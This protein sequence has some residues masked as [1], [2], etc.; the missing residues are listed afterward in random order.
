MSKKLTVE[1]FR[2]RSE[3]KHSKKYG[4]DRVKFDKITDK[5][6]ILCNACQEYFTQ[7]VNDHLRGSGCPKC[8]KCG[9]KKLSPEEFLSRCKEKYPTQ[10]DF[11]ETKYIVSENK[12][13]IRCNIC[14]HS[15]E[16]M[17]SDFLNSTVGCRKCA[18]KYR[19][20][21]RRISQ[22]EFLARMQILHGNDYDYSDVD[23]TTRDGKI[24]IYCKTCREFFFQKADYHMNGSKCPKCAHIS[25][26][27]KRSLHKKEIIERANLVHLGKYDYSFMEEYPTI[28]GGLATIVCSIHGQFFQNIGNHLDGC[29]CPTCAAE[30]RGKLLSLGKDEFVKRSSIMHVGMY[31]Y[32]KVVYTNAVTKVEIICSVHG[33]FW[34][35]PQHHLAGSG[36]PQCRISSGEREIIRFL[37]NKN[38]IYVF[39]KKF[40][41]LGRLSYD[42]Y[43]PQQ[44]I[45]IEYDGIQHFEPTDFGSGTAVALREFRLRKANDLLKTKY[46]SDN[47][48][49]LIR[50]AYKDFDRIEEILMT[51]LGE[52]N[53]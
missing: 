20:A 13:K 3:K 45:L 6:E 53:A 41:D 12:V 15:F 19:G 7:V 1:V 48:I 4:Y 46:A 39:E 22:K 52:T 10:F 17:P 21:K 42:F 14:G 16:V 27:Q 11:S 26:V 25:S 28:N 47:N 31:D 24:K 9:R 2:E 40:K 49:R 8:N 51:T 38:I 23:Y 44:N 30:E 43:L 32:S 36:C 5:V 33:V 50:I 29:G 35:E 18:D 34:Q 37:K